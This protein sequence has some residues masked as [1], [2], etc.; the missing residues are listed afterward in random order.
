MSTSNGNNKR[1]HMDAFDNLGEPNVEAL[2]IRWKNTNPTK[3]PTVDKLAEFGSVESKA[4]KK[5]LD[6]KN[7]T[8][9]NMLQKHGFRN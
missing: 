5:W 7:T 3:K 9:T 1:T 8:W 6:M 2:L 4:L